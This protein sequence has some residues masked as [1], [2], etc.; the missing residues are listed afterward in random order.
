MK[1]NASFRT[2]K[3]LKFIILYISLLLCS[4]FTASAQQIVPRHEGLAS[5]TEYMEL[6]KR[7]A[8]LT[9]AADSIGSVIA[10]CRRIIAESPEKRDTYA[11]DILRLESELFDIRT[12]LGMVTTRTNIIEQEYIIRNISVTDR[13]EQ[14]EKRD[15]FD[16]NLSEGEK[17]AIRSARASDTLFVRLSSSLGE[18]VARREAVYNGYMSATDKRSADSLAVTFDT[19]SAEIARLDEEMSARWVNVYDTLRYAYER[20]LDKINT[21]PS[22]TEPVMEMSRNLRS[23]R[24]EAPAHYAAPAL[25]MYERQKRMLAT[26]EKLLADRLQMTEAYDSLATLLARPRTN[27]CDYRL[28][29]LPELVF[30]DFEPLKTGASGAMSANNPPKPLVVPSRGDFFKVELLTSNGP[31]SD[32]RALRNVNNVEYREIAGDKF[33]YYA[34][35]YRLRNEAARD[36][37]RL[38]RTGIKARVAAWRD[39]VPVDENGVAIEERPIGDIFRVIVY[40]MDDT[41]RGIIR[42]IAP[43]KDLLATETDDETVISVGPFEE[44]EKAL[45][46]AKSL[47]KAKVVGQKTDAE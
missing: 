7:E 19:V 8:A 10:E 28:L 36:C 14:D 3:L 9:T 11:S 33:V 40:S 4:P 21:P 42:D 39:G 25:A 41:A 18:A 47:P 45:F 34:G 32:Y 26:Y 27:P 38:R 13:S 16:E 20:L 44:Y 22:L 30:V 17:R 6:L 35:S 43:D 46:L 2:M 15:F 12:N 37:D 31:L 5:D 24:S 1:S 29:E 23:R